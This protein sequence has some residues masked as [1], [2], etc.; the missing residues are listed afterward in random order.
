MRTAIAIACE[1]IASLR[2]YDISYQAG[3]HDMTSATRPAATKA[4]AMRC[5]REHA[6]QWL[7]LRYC[8]ANKRRSMNESKTDGTTFPRRRVGLS[9]AADGWLP[10]S[11]R[12]AD[13]P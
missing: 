13:I 7:R 8:R 1:G 9:L 12:T 3:S 10:N 11:M 6:A 4:R 2:E 5:L